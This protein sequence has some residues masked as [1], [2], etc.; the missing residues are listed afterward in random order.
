MLNGCDSVTLYVAADTN[1]VMDPAKHFI[2][3]DPQQKI[4][5]RLANMDKMTFE[6]MR[7]E[8]A[9]DIAKLFDRCTLD[10]ATRTPEAESLPT[11]KRKTEN[12]SRMYRQEAHDV[13]LQAL[14]FD[15]VRYMMIACSRPGSLP[16]NLQGLWNVGKSAEWT[17]DYH[18]DINVQMNYWFVEPA[19]LAECATPLF[20]YIESQIPYWRA[21][22]KQTFGEK[23]RGWTVD[24]MNNIFGGGAYM[25]YPPGSAWLSWHYDQHFEFGQDMD[26]LKTRAYPVLKELSEHWQ[27]L[28]IERPDGQLTTTFTMSPEHKPKQ[29]GIAQD[30]QMVYDLL[31]NYVAAAARMNQDADFAKQVEDL[32]KRIV[33]PLI[34]RWGQLQE[35]EIDRDSRFCKHRHM[36]HEFAAFPGR[37]INPQ[38]PEL[39]RAAAKS[40]IA[41]G[42]GSTGWS[43]AWR[44]SIYARLLDT[45][46]A[47]SRLAAL[48]SMFHDNLI[49]QGKQQID[50][51]CGYASGVCEMLLQSYKP[52][53]ASDSRYE[54]HLLPA[55]P[56][57]WP[58]GRVKGMRARGGFEVDQEW[59]DGKLTHAVIRNVASPSD[60]CTVRYNGVTSTFTVARGQSHLYVP[61]Q[62]A[63]P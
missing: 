52:L 3:P 22:A 30:R 4:A 6:Q 7:D 45:E 13:G 38:T 49:W 44:I 26:F 41:R 11:D 17:G 55:V 18:T 15:A 14:T 53:D 46:R 37:E 60:Q 58:A 57:Q 21:K 51:P 24:Y 42:G 10:L 1:Y 54:I 32:R 20:D 35:W 61:V 62:N 63:Q 29:F 25:N 8:S 19:N 27:D 34:G 36:M 2:G 47:Y 48:P 59:S 50:A 56:R 33:P 12:R 43:V 28:L 40:L 9:A 23:V 16:A 5:P 39:A 31:T